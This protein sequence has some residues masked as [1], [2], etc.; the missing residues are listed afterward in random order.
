M[1]RLRFQSARLSTRL[2]KLARQEIF[3]GEKETHQERP[4]RLTRLFQELGNHHQLLPVDTEVPRNILNQIHA[5]RYIGA[6]IKLGKFATKYHYPSVFPYL[7]RADHQNLT[8]LRALQGQF[9]FD[10]YTPV[11]PQLWSIALESA[12]TAHQVAQLILSGQ[13]RFCYALIRPP[14]HHAEPAKMGGYC[15]LNNAAIA[16]QTLTN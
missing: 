3:D 1:S 15:Y 9:S 5:K 4:Q 6:L 2:K 8:L 12:S 13:E 11:H 10:M 16:T 14:G 7:G